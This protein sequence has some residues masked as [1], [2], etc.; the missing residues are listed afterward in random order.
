M[1]DSGANSQIR[2]KGKQNPVHEQIQVHSK[3]Y[4]TWEQIT[5]SK[6]SLTRLILETRGFHML[7]LLW[8]IC[9]SGHYNSVQIYSRWGETVLRLMPKDWELMNKFSSSNKKL[10]SWISH[11][12]FHIFNILSSPSTLWTVHKGTI[13]YLI[14]AIWKLSLLIFAELR[15]IKRC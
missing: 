13:I 4:L 6:S 7:F 14:R 8:N 11:I 3:P 2:S 1:Q 5:S 15:L 10:H 9:T 12:A